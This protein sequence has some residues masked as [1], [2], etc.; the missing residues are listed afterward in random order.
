M[1]P[2]TPA[3]GVLA[4]PMVVVDSTSTSFHT[5]LNLMLAKTTGDTK[6]V[7]RVN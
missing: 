2:A 4:Q 1:A 6:R 7:G 3:E 5:H